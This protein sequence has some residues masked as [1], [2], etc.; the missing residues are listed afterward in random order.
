MGYVGQGSRGS[1][2]RGSWFTW[3]MGHV[4]C[5]SRG[6]W[7]TF[8]KGHVGQCA[9]VCHGSHVTRVTWVMGHIGYGSRRSLVTH[10]VRDDNGSVG[11]V[12]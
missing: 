3:V 1:W 6:S 8:V 10:R 7:V 2:S 4:S 12:H 11:E 5:G 9:Y